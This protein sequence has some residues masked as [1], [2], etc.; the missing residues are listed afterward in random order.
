MGQRERGDG[1]MKKYISDELYCADCYALLLRNGQCP[2]CADESPALSGAYLNGE[3]QAAIPD[4]FK[5]RRDK[6]VPA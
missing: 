3:V 4:N 1:S 2:S 6:R 5:W